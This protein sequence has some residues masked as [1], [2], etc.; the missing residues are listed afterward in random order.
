MDFTLSGAAKAPA[1]Q[2]STSLHLFKPRRPLYTQP[3]PLQLLGAQPQATPPYLVH[4][5]SLATPN[6]T[7]LTVSHP[8]LLTLIDKSTAATLQSFRPSGADR[9]TQVH[10]LSQRG[11]AAGFIA[12][13]T[14]GTIQSYDLRSPN[15]LAQP[16]LVLKGTRSAPFLSVATSPHPSNPHLVAAGTE[17]LGV[18][19]HVE[20]WD[21]RNP[22]APLFRYTESH[23]DDITS[24][25]FHPSPG[26]ADILLT[27]STDGL[28]CA[29]DTT[30]QDEDDAV[31]AVGNMGSSVARVGWGGGGKQLW[32]QGA[33]SGQ[34]DVDM[35]VDA[36][37]QVDEDLRLEE[38]D[39]RRRSLGSVWAVGDMQ[40]LSIWD[41]DKFDAL[42]D[43]VDVRSSTCLRP[44]WTTDY[45]I[46]AHCSSQLLPSAST[47][48]A[49]AS[50][51]FVMPSAG[52]ALYTGTTS[53]SFSILTASPEHAGGWKMEALFPEASED[54]SRPGHSD[55]VRCVE[56]DATTRMLYS[57]GED[58]R[59]CFWRVA[60]DDGDDAGTAFAQLQQSQLVAPPNTAPAPA[61]NS[62]AAFGGAMRTGS[63][64]TSE[65]GSSRNSPRNEAPHSGRSQ[66]WKPYG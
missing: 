54:G 16:A 34:G 61:S 18:D 5:A 19:A 66:R 57:G 25:R 45:I 4:L 12:S 52:V 15:A 47:D 29:I 23:S 2:P 59:L 62:P 60:T 21:A 50:S 22:G 49:S 41:A 46:D 36:K 48:A 35:M 64:P 33:A 9:F 39:T 56:Y 8:S 44:M 13:S 40:T 7:L 30:V 53:G 28:V 32:G 51:P 10:A 6:P 55:I 20:I 42:L 63:R 31:I 24:L 27:G 38:D 26:H 37:A 43:P 17:L 58:G 14:N 1:L 65:S 3:V 11:A